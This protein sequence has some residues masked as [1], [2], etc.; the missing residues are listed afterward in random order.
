M[1]VAVAAR[2]ASLRMVD[3]PVD[4][5]R[6]PECNLELTSVEKARRVRLNGLCTDCHEDGVTVPPLVTSEPAEQTESATTEL[7]TGDVRR[8]GHCDG[9]I[10]TLPDSDFCSDYCRQMAAASGTATVDTLST[11]PAT[12]RKAPQEPRDPALDI[13]VGIVMFAYP[14]IT[15]YQAVTG[16]RAAVAHWSNGRVA[17]RG[18]AAAARAWTPA[19]EDYDNMR[20]H[21]QGKANSRALPI[22]K[23][24]IRAA[25]EYR[26]AHRPA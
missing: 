5:C 22:L 8:C 24:A 4:T 10:A 7:E 11:E 21:Q 26:A 12:A 19:G 14:D 16:L 2:A 3:H 23:A 18:I 17:G 25:Q 6:N 15:E 13:A 1:T 9:N 20:S